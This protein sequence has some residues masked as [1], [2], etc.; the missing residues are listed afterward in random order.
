MKELAVAVAF[1]DVFAAVDFGSEAA[2]FQFN[3]LRTQTHGAAQIGGF[4]AGFDAAVGGLPF[5]NQGDDGRG[6]FEVELG[7]I[8]AFQAC[9]V[10]GVF[11]Q[12]NLH[13]ETDAQVWRSRSEERRVGKECRSRWSP[14]H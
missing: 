2:C 12:R 4:V 14:Y 13:T 9:Y 8:R 11:D 3:L 6:A 7:G 5:V 10:A 1:S